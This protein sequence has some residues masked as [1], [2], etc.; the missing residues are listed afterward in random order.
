M[1]YSPS[2]TWTVT[3]EASLE[4][5]KLICEEKNILDMNSYTSTLPAE[6]AII[7]EPLIMW[8]KKTLEAREAA[9]NY[10]KDSK[11]IDIEVIQ[12]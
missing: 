1:K 8:I 6:V 9:I 4:N 7:L 10:F 12:T 2:E 3:K 11:G 5:I